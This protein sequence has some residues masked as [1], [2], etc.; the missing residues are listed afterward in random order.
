MTLSRR[1]FML[2]CAAGLSTGEFEMATTPLERRRGVREML[3]VFADRC[4]SM[5][6]VSAPNCGAAFSDRLA[7][8]KMFAG[9]TEPATPRH[10]AYIVGTGA[11]ILGAWS[12][13]PLE[14]LLGEV[15]GPGWKS[16]VGNLPV[17]KSEV[18]RFCLA[19]GD[20]DEFKWPLI[21]HVSRWEYSA[22]FLLEQ[23]HGLVERSFRLEGDMRMIDPADYKRPPVGRFE[24][25]SRSFGVPFIADRWTFADE[26]GGVIPAGELP[27][28]RTAADR[29]GRGGVMGA[30][31]HGYR[32]NFLIA[33]D[34]RAAASY[35]AAGEII[36]EH[37]PILYLDGRPRKIGASDLRVVCARFTAPPGC[38]DWEFSIAKRLVYSL[39][40]A[41]LALMQRITASSVAVEFFMAYPQIEDAIAAA[42]R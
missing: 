30:S 22:N 34:S 8:C 24:R 9:C 16:G 17:L 4:R 29:I 42:L 2:A 3:S 12:L 23:E 35:Q 41:D 39:R 6:K 21:I 37:C 32:E 26:R 20:G 5:R 15:L 40:P 25:S 28:L 7:A 36:L 13:N 19:G 31:T 1:T 38:K 18:E 10:S 11:A 14:H 27:I 33:K